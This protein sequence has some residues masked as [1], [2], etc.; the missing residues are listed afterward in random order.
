VNLTREVVERRI[1]HQI[2]EVTYHHAGSNPALAT[3]IV[4]MEIAMIVGWV[5]LI[6]SWTIPSFIKDVPIKDVSKRRF[7]GLMLS[8]L[9]TGVF[10][11]H[12]LSLLF[13]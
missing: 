4:I 8:T 10:I 9:A 1:K 12:G 7:V 3:K 6:S 5:F 2:D 13:S 11:G